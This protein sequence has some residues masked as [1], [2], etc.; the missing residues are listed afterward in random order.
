MRVKAIRVS[1]VLKALKMQDA[2][3]VHVQNDWAE[4][5]LKHQVMVIT[6]CI[7]SG[8]TLILTNS[9]EFSIRIGSKILLL[10]SISLRIFDN[11]RAIKPSLAPCRFRSYTLP[12]CHE[13]YILLAGGLCRESV[14]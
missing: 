14:I 11:F 12:R 1:R 8:I 9:S 6:V 3:C 5:S 10:A 13:P 4:K 7:T 2:N